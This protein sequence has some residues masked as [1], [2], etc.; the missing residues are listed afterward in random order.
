[1]SRLRAYSTAAAPLGLSMTVSAVWAQQQPDP[2]LLKAKEFFESAGIPGDK[3]IE[4]ETMSPYVAPASHFNATML[5]YPGT[6]AP[7]A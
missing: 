1:M 4:G 3:W 7:T 5:Y 6:V 2:E